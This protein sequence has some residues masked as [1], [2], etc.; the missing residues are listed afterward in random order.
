MRK[1]IENSPNQL[2][3]EPVI[4]NADNLKLAKKFIVSGMG[5]S[6]LAADLI[7]TW[8]PS[9]DMIVHHDYG[10]PQVSDSLKKYLTIISSYS[11]N[12]EE[13]L[14]GFNIAV[15]QK[16]P[17]A[18]ISVGGKLL[19][20]AKEYKK[21]Y[22]QMPDTAIEPRS[23]LGFSAVSLLK[24]MGQ[25]NALS[26]MR[27]ISF[28][29][30]ELEEKGKALAERIK[31]HIPVIYTSTVNG[32]IGYNWKIRFN[33]TGKIPAFC[34]TIPEL[35]HNEMVGFDREGESRELSD[36]F[37]FIFLK[38]NKDHKRNLLRMDIT[39]EI[40]EEKGLAVEYLELAGNN[41]W[42]KIFSS[43]LLADW[44]AFYTAQIYKLEAQETAI[45]TRFKNTI[46]ERGG[47]I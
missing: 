25:E 43:L 22:I 30:P 9:F 38:D 16:L 20:M 28:N 7:K 44:T 1:A 34:N 40:L 10:L 8:E 42:E 4:E 5:G 12:T 31:G 21:P 47:L 23:A 13:A 2:R 3:F 27:K 41:I 45:I 37:Y 15:S 29:M 33:E 39:K 24:M 19:E 6:H 35:N 14:D 32:P 17:V 36:S 46:K 11:G 18:A 26:E